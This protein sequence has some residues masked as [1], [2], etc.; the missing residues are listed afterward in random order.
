MGLYTSFAV[1][2]DAKVVVDLSNG[3]EDY[4]A[5]LRFGQVSMALTEQQLSDLRWQAETAWAELFDFCPDC[6]TP[7]DE[8]HSSQCGALDLPG[9]DAE[10]N[11]RMTAGW[12]RKVYGFSGLASLADE[13]PDGW[14]MAD[15]EKNSDP[16]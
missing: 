4:P 1:D 11:D 15:P 13:V 12:A 5:T 6:H 9:R 8:P 3:T 2:G 14:G 10:G 16:S 7:P